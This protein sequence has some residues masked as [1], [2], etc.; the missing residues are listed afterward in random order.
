MRLLDPCF[1]GISILEI[2][3]SRMLKRVVPLQVIT[4]A[5]QSATNR[6]SMPIPM[7]EMFGPSLVMKEVIEKTGIMNGKVGTVVGMMKGTGER[8]NIIS[9]L[10]CAPDMTVI[11]KNKG[12]LKNAD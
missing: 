10:M 1:L 12:E 3:T 8:G 6:L 5:R 9:M 4:T 7:P 11:A 2:G